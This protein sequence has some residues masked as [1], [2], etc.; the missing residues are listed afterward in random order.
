MNNKK[1]KSTSKFLSLVLRHQPEVIGINLDTQGWVA[2]DELLQKLAAY[3]R[4]ISLEE[5]DFVVENN[6]KK[7]FAFNKDKTKI[8]AS[9]GHSINL[10]LGYAPVEPPELLYHGT[11]SRFLE[12]IQKT[13]LE[14]RNR[15]HLH[16]SL[17]L[18]TAKDVGGRHGKPVILVVRAK[19]MHE[20]GFQFFVSDND[21]WLTD[22]V[23]LDF[24]DFPD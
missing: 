7:R 16:L 1:I 11:A 19:E 8:R 12:G 14:K 5:L 2:V 4:G 20:A 21:V 10:D 6:N 23:P 9:Q 3:K 18:D 22:H 13:G 15:H 17:N 24:I